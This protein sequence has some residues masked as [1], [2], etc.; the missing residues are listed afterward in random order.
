MGGRQ[1]R[2]TATRRKTLKAEMTEA[3]VAGKFTTN[4]R[5]L[6]DIL[7]EVDAGIKNDFYPIEVTLDGLIEIWQLSGNPID[8]AP[9]EAQTAAGGEQGAPPAA[10]TQDPIAADPYKFPP[11]KHADLVAAQ[12]VADA[13]GTQMQVMEAAMGPATVPGTVEHAQAQAAMSQT[14]YNGPGSTPHMQAIQAKADDQAAR[15][16]ARGDGHPA[17]SS[18]QQSNVMLN[19][20]GSAVHPLPGPA[21][22]PGPAPV[23]SVTVLPDQAQV[24][25]QQAAEARADALMHP[26]SPV[27]ESKQY[28]QMS[29]DPAVQAAYQQAEEALNVQG[30]SIHNP[31]PVHEVGVPPAP[32]EEKPV[33]PVDLG[34]LE[35][36]LQ[37]AANG[38]EKIRVGKEVYDH[39]MGQI[40]DY[41]DAQGG[42]DIS[43]SGQINGREKVRRTFIRRKNF[44]KSRLLAEHPEIDPELY[45]DESVFYKTEL[46]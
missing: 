34:P 5:A 39:A 7:D 40:N 30:Q 32:A 4:G 46:K 10:E 3:L 43:K 25:E 15:I 12:Q 9:E 21:A 13:G 41:L 17:Y 27:P 6:D 36:W 23:T 38:Q 18:A 37:L 28:P 20:D 16:A 24:A 19:P 45:S 29:T 11:R 2:L 8:S 22:A 33:V 26:A 44:A 31:P 42:P 35:E 1:K 14:P